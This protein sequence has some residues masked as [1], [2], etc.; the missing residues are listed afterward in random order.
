MAVP[1]VVGELVGSP[2][3]GS[4]ESPGSSYSCCSQDLSAGQRARRRRLLLLL[5]LLRLLFPTFGALLYALRAPFLRFPINETLFVDAFTDRWSRTNQQLDRIWNTHVHKHAREITREPRV[6]FSRGNARVCTSNVRG[7]RDLSDE[8]LAIEHRP[9][10]FDSFHSL[11]RFSHSLTLSLSFFSSF[12]R[13]Y[14]SRSRTIGE[15]RAS[16]R[17]NAIHRTHRCGTLQTKDLRVASRRLESKKRLACASARVH[18]RDFRKQGDRNEFPRARA[19]QQTLLNVSRVYFVP[20][21]HFPPLY[22]RCT[23]A[24]GCP[25]YFG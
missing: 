23:V 7:R 14:R 18:A 12:H 20:S 22:R 8:D 19:T 24:R 5:L 25:S 4:P 16:L 13:L 2:V 10:P 9:F 11:L 17:S 15:D 1:I 6:C 21:V 3:V